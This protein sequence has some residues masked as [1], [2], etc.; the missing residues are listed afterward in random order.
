MAVLVWGVVGCCVRGGFLGVSFVAFDFLCIWVNRN[1]VVFNNAGWNL[2]KIFL[3]VKTLCW[4][5]FSILS[6]GNGEL[7]NIV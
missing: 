3:F 1:N 7:N 2:G 4:D 5:W 6:K